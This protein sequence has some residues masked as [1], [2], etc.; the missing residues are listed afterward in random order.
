VI[1][2]TYGFYLNASFNTTLINSTS[3]NNTF[4]I[5]ISGGGNNTLIDITQMQAVYG[6]Y[7]T[8]QANNNSMR[9]ATA[10]NNT[11]AGF[12]LQNSHW[13]F[14]YNSSSGVMTGPCPIAYCDGFFISASQNNTIANSTAYQNVHYGFHLKS[15]S[16]WNL[17]INSTSRNS[18]YGFLLSD[19][20]NNTLFNNSVHGNS[21]YG[22]SLQ[23][24]SNNNTVANNTVFNNTQGGISFSGTSYNLLMNNSVF[25][26]LL[27]AILLESSGFLNFIFNNSAFSATNGVYLSSSFNNTL[28]NNTIFN[29]TI[30]IYAYNEIND[31][32]MNNSLSSADLTLNN[33]LRGAE[34]YKG[35]NN[36]LANNTINMFQPA[37][38]DAAS[39]LL[40]LSNNNSVLNNYIGAS[41]YGILSNYS[42]FTRASNNTLFQVGALLATSGTIWFNSSYFG[43]I[44]NNSI[45]QARVHPVYLT[46]SGYNYIYNNTIY[47]NKLANALIGIL[48]VSS[49]NNTLDFNYLYDND[50]G[51]QA[52]A[53]DNLTIA[54]NTVR[55]SLLHGVWINYTNGTW[56]WNNSAIANAGGGGFNISNSDNVTLAN[57]TAWANAIDGFYIS[58]SYNITLEN[59]TALTNKVDGF[60]WDYS[61]TTRAINNSALNN[62]GAGF[63]ITGAWWSYFQNASAIN[64]SQHGFMLTSSENNTIGNLTVLYSDPAGSFGSAGL[65]MLNSINNTFREVNSTNQFISAVSSGI[66]M[67]GSDNNYFYNV[68]L[69][70]NTYGVWFRT[71]DFNEFNN[72]TVINGS[73]GIYFMSGAD[74]NYFINSSVNYRG[75][76]V[77]SVWVASGT[78]NTFLNSSVNRTR[79]SFDPITETTKDAVMFWWYG[80]INVSDYAEMPIDG[81][82]F[83]IS[84][85]TFE[86]QFINLTE[87]TGLSNWTILREGFMNYSS[88]PLLYNETNHTFNASKSGYETNWTNA[89][90]N[91][92]RIVKVYIKSAVIDLSFT[93]NYPLTG[94]KSGEGNAS[95]SALPC[96]SGSTCACDRAW[97][98]TTDTEGLADQTCVAPQGQTSSTGFLKFTNTGNRPEAWSVILNKSL[99]ANYKLKYNQTK[100]EITD[101]ASD[102]DVLEFPSWPTQ[103]NVS[104]NVSIPTGEW[105][106]AWI[107]GDFIGA[108]GGMYVE[109]LNSTALNITP[110]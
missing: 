75:G 65:Y 64:N 99:G 82:F 94:C 52:H 15:F 57:N 31:T 87:P 70:N 83:N 44:S 81:A 95:E 80:R 76:L 42:N 56:L 37:P 17:I 53:S 110:P 47:T 6:Y 90:M 89:T 96:D 32:I 74:S 19:S 67:Q 40:M 13:N 2:S 11:V 105:D 66:Y 8:A 45:T 16:D 93:L 55:E 101:C 61:N 79:A 103:G 73:Y 58:F 98:V 59:N 109:Q 85:L 10:F 30:G 78:N 26:N 1:N 3:F 48:L 69:E 63:N 20:N 27:Y 88:V 106:E 9:N 21:Q 28:A 14:I 86:I 97:I 60:R 12:Y 62:S 4:G 100:D 36:T 68:S 7:L 46:S 35:G 5:Y 107:Y 92:S 108:G 72:L 33:F 22:M 104:I 54:N 41:S 50:Y 29:N 24:G 43:E 18:T 38:A 84:N 77:Y 23:S 49:N 34:L 91:E 39:V 71:S 25:N 51:I 102:L